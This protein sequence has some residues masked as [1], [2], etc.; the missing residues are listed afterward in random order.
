MS[1]DDSSG[2]KLLMTVAETARYLRV[3][4]KAVRSLM[5]HAQLPVIRVTPHRVLI[6]L[7][8]LHAW[9]RTYGLP[10]PDPKNGSVIPFPDTPKPNLYK[11]DQYDNL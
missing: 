4:E 11:E 9:L 2:P 8:Q 7:S 10:A 1:T 5:A 6:S 3:G